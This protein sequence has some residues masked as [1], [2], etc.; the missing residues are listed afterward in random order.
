MESQLDYSIITY[1]SRC[2]ARVEHKSHWGNKLTALLLLL[3]LLLLCL[4]K[5][6]VNN[7]GTHNK[8]QSGTR[9]CEGGRAKAK[10]NADISIVSV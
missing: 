5:H 7:K 2:P 6:V 10:A 8:R 3:L 1:T 4:L 9:E